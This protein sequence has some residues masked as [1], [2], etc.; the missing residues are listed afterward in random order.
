MKCAPSTGR[1]G[2]QLRAESAW[3]RSPEWK[4]PTP[5]APSCAGCGPS[6]A[7]R[8]AVRTST[9]HSRPGSGR[10]GRHRGPFGEDIVV[11]GFGAN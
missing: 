4:T 10:L 8:F 2:R 3:R 7:G 5:A 1:T 11:N 9:F 6:L